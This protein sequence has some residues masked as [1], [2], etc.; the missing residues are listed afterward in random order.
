L[1]ALWLQVDRQWYGP[2]LLWTRDD[3]SG[4]WHPDADF[5]PGAPDAPPDEPP[6]P[7]AASPGAAAAA[8]T[9]RRGAARGRAAGGKRGGAA[10]AAPAPASK[11]AP[12]AAAAAASPALKLED[13]EAALQACLCLVDVDVPL[14][15][16]TDGVH[17]RS[18]A[19]NGVV[20]FQVGPGVEPP[21]PPRVLG[22]RWG[23]VQRAAARRLL[24]GWGCPGAIRVVSR[25][26]AN[27]QSPSN[28]HFKPHRRPPKP[29][30]PQ[31]S[32]IGLVLVD[33][34][35]VAIG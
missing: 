13:F 4:A 17:S 28:R 3:A 19:G 1:R 11:P 16:L 12:S 34:N 5:P 8:A 27:P 23:L 9:P 18:F 21:P 15:A 6:P 22:P 24:E 10:G 25:H 32:K 14:V 2:P 29:L 26:S 7:A 31:G 20:V 30:T 33:R 35:T